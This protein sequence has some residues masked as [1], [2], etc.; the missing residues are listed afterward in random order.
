[1][2][3]I[4]KVVKGSFGM[5]PDLISLDVKFLIFLKVLLMVTQS[6]MSGQGVFNLRLSLMVANFSG[7]RYLLREFRFTSLKSLTLLIPLLR[8]IKYGMLVLPF[9]LRRS[10]I[11][12]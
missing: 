8:M 7:G 11:S 6:R 9:G 4:L 12:E 3:P 1:M 2:V 10:P 5:R